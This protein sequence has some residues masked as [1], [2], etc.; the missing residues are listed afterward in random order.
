MRLTFW[1]VVGLSTAYAFIYLLITV[2]VQF[3]RAQEMARTTDG[4]FFFVVAAMPPWWVALLFLPPLLLTAL[5]IWQR[6]R[7]GRR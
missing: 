1:R 7:R 6:V 4:E 3:R 2:G 5:W